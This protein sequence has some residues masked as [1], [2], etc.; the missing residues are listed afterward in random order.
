MNL[1]D[2]S[3]GLVLIIED[4]PINRILMRRSLNGA[5]NVLIPGNKEEFDIVLKEIRDIY[6][7]LHGEVQIAILL[8]HNLGYVF[9]GAQEMN[10]YQMMEY[11]TRYFEECGFPLS[12]EN[13]YGIS[14]NPK[15]QEHYIEIS[16]QHIGKSTG[17]LREFYEDFCSGDES[18]WTELSDSK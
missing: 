6:N 15:N 13:F 1:N 7:N 11:I 5:A 2:L 4:E 8:D 16:K 14:D 18:E 9:S 3:C 12:A 10:G 17:Q